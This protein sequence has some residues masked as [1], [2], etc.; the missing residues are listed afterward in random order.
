MKY[1][2]SL[3][4]LILAIVATS[5]TTI[6]DEPGPGSVFIPYDVVDC[7]I[8]AT[9]I[10][11]PLAAAA[12][13][14]KVWNVSEM[15]VY[16]DWRVNS[17]DGKLNLIKE[18]VRKE[19]FTPTSPCY[20]SLP[21]NYQNSQTGDKVEDLPLQMI[22]EKGTIGNSKDIVTLGSVIKI[23]TEEDLDKPAGEDSK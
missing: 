4:L 23:L 21:S 11:N 7:T 5:C 15:T 10:N 17:G 16:R 6:S 19:T 3:A 2:K 13:D 12:S 9:V 1:I 14:S 18:E 20:V 22:I 8:T